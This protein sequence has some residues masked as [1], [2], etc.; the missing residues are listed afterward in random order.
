MGNYTPASH[1]LV[2]GTA[3]ARI[4][5]AL[6]HLASTIELKPLPLLLELAKDELDGAFIPADLYTWEGLIPN[7]FQPLFFGKYKVPIERFVIPLK[8]RSK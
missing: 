1:Q 4:H 3:V 6:V 7:E 5:S 8:D 2:A